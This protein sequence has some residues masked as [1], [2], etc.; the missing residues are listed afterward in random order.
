MMTAF[1][2]NLGRRSFSLVGGALLSAT[3]SAHHSQAPYDMSVEVVIE[4]T[5]VEL[6]WRN[7][8]IAMMLEVVGENGESF[9]QEVEVASVS[10]VRAL[11]V[12]QDAI[13]IGS[14]VALQAHP[15]R[16]GPEA[17]VFGLGLTRSD[18]TRI[19]LHP[20]AGFAYG[21]DVSTE[22]DSLA[23]RWAPSGDA[24]TGIFGVFM[25]WP[26]T[27]AAGAS[28]QDALGQSGASLGVCADYPLP[29][30]SIFPDLREIVIGEETVVMRFEAQ[31]QNLER[32]IR[33][34]VAEH[35][36]GTEPSLLGHSIGRWEGETLVVDTIAFTPHPH[37]AF[38]WVASGPDKHLVERFSLAE[39]RLHLRYE[40]IMEDPESLAAPGTLSMLWDY[41]PDLE[42]SGVACDPEIA[43]RLLHD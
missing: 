27:D 15:G 9:L 35:P 6:E 3:A 18:G 25:S 36:A 14:K 8:H 23:G 1:R 12:D 34:D 41:R 39:D 43:E 29:L 38:A 32:V 17:R 30:V 40:V 16:R 22:A 31:G 5:I 21:S 20:F 11:G 10:E 28:L 26:Y 37:G 7:P 19:P 33:M 13:P 4:G 2:S 24:L 42:P